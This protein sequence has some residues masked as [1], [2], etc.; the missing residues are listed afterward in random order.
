MYALP[1]QN[2]IKPPL[3]ILSTT[4]IFIKFIKFIFVIRVDHLDFI[5]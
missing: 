1:I 4:I 5:D 3:A 2:L